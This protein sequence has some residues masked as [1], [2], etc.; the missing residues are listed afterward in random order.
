MTKKMW[1]LLVLERREKQTPP[2]PPFCRDLPPGLHPPAAFPWRNR[3]SRYR[4]A[5]FPVLQSA[6]PRCGR[7]RVE[8]SCFHPPLLNCHLQFTTVWGALGTW[9]S[10]VTGWFHRVPSPVLISAQLTSSR[11]RTNTPL[12]P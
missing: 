3:G 1:W 6:S 5:W 7:I 2:P 12:V 10:H 9:A 11:R 4:C 8:Y